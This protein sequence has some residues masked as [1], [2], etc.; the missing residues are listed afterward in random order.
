VGADFAGFFED[1]DAEVV[2]ACCGGELF[3]AD[4]GGESCWACEGRVLAF[5]LPFMLVYCGF[6]VAPALVLCAGGRQA[7]R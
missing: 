7:S 3:E 2:V 1:D 6:V 4:G 5:I